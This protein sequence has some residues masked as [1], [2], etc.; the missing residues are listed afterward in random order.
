MAATGETNMRVVIQVFGGPDV[1]TVERGGAI[2]EPGDGEVL[3][4][5]EASSAAFTDIIIRKGLY[6][7]LPE[8]PPFT[9]GYDMVGTVER[10]GSGADAFAPGTR[11]ADLTT[12]GGQAR[13]VCRRQ[14]DLTIVPDGIAPVD[15][16]ALILSYVTAWQM[17]MRV[18]KVPQGG[19]ILVHGAGGAVGT[20]MLELARLNGIAAWGTDFPEKHDLISNLGGTPLDAGMEDLSSAIP[21]GVDAAFDPLGGASY[22][23]SLDVVKPGGMLV[24]YGFLEQALGHGGSIPM[25]FIKL[26][27]WDWLPNGHATAF[28]SIGAMRRKHPAWFHEDLSHLFALLAQGRL[29]PTIE[30]TL[31]ME[32]VRA[33]HEA[34]EAG[35]VRG[36]IV[37]LPWG[38]A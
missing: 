15:A 12:I 5:V 19:R 22:A 2:P 17:L 18:A 11:V 31:P 26:R 9:L 37:L 25:D 28:Y 33:A 36:K 14:D 8:K 13:F 7:G 27:L 21:G 32:Q 30:K 35:E 29:T 3:V 6:P 16:A 24:G 1:L 38:E 23:R 10:N 34:I 4:R 20:A